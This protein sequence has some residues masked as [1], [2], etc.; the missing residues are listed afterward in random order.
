MTHN[1]NN[2]TTTSNS[3]KITHNVHI[4]CGASDGEN[5]HGSASQCTDGMCWNGDVI[6]LQWR[7]NKHPVVVVQH[8]LQHASFINPLMER[9]QTPCRC[10]P[11]CTSA[12]I[13]HQLADVWNA[14]SVLVIL[15]G[16]C[17][18]WRPMHLWVFQWLSSVLSGLETTAHNSWD[19]SC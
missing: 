11:A 8:A 18:C 13:A 4:M 9:E 14:Y 7:W 6:K 17:W 12:C 1:W 10:R 5:R 16:L 15:C 3:N 19:V 2:N